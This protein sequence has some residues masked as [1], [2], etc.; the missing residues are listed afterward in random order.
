MKKT[1]LFLLAALLIGVGSAFTTA[2]PAKFTTVY[3]TT[4]GG[5]S[6]ISVQQED[7]G[8]TFECL[9]GSS[10]CTYASQ[11]INDPIGD[12]DRLFHKLN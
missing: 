11:N 9:E 1:K 4:N 2:K 7:E 12:Q 6:W 3:A 10:Y 5:A 8:N